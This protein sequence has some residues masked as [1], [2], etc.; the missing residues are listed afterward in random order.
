LAEASSGQQVELTDAL[1]IMDPKKLFADSR[2]L[3]GCVYCGAQ[4]DTRDHIPSKVL[5]D[6]PFPCDLGVV[7]SCC[8]CNNGFSADEQYLACFIECVINGSTAPDRV[9]REKIKRTLLARPAIA[10][11]IEACKFDGPEGQTWWKPDYDRIKRVVLKLAQGHAAYDGSEFCG[12]DPTEL[13]MAPLCTMS[14]ADLLEFETP[15]VDYVWP[16]IGSRAFLRAC[17]VGSDAFLDNGWQVI[18]RNRYRYLIGY[19]GPLRIRIVLSE[20]LACE[21]VW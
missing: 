2:L 18:Q 1:R 3:P 14:P 8:D 13:T 12:D 20:Y 7:G 15:P 4:A 6:E 5:L 16:E 17:G 9:Q 10:A 19:T 11:A 21:V